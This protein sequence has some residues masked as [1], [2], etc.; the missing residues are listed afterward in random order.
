MSI[1]ALS[2]SGLSPASPVG[3]AY[4][5]SLTLSG[6]VVKN[7]YT[8][9]GVT[10]TIGTVNGT[11]STITLAG[12]NAAWTSAMAAN[13]VLQ[14]TAGT[15]SLGTGTVTVTSVVSSTSVNISST[16]AMTAGTIT[17]LLIVSYGTGVF[18]APASLTAN[19]TLS[20]NGLTLS[21]DKINVP[22]SNIRINSFN[23]N[24]SG[25][26]GTIGTVAGSGSAWTANLTVSDTSVLHVGMKVTSAATGTSAGAVGT[27]AVI[28]SITNSTVAVIFSTT[29]STAG[30][31]TYSFT[32]LGGM[33][34]QIYADTLSD[35]KIVGA[36]Q[37]SIWG[38][39]DKTDDGLNAI[40][41][42]SAKIT[43]R[44]FTLSFPTYTE[45]YVNG[46][47]VSSSY[48]K[49][50]EFASPVSI[51]GRLRLRAPAYTSQGFPTG[52]PSQ[53]RLTIESETI[54]SASSLATV[55]GITLTTS[56]TVTGTWAVGQEVRG[57]GITAGSMVTAVSGPTSG[58]YTVTLDRSS[59]INTPTALTGTPTIWNIDNFGGLFRI[60]REDWSTDTL[61]S[62]ITGST[63]LV[64]TNAGEVGI[65]TNPVNAQLHVAAD[66]FASTAQSILENT[67]T[68]GYANLLIR[69]F[70]STY[71][72][73]SLAGNSTIMFFTN[74][75][76][77]T[78]RAR[79]VI[80]S[81]SNLYFTTGAYSTERMRITSSG[82]VG[83]GTSSPS[84]TLHVTGTVAGAVAPRCVIS[85]GSFIPNSVGPT[86]AYIT[87][88]SD[89]YE[90]QYGDGTDRIAYTTF[91]V[92]YN[93]SG[94]SIQI[95][96]YW[97]ISSGINSQVRWEGWAS[98][99]VSS[100]AINS[101]PAIV[102]S[103]NA[104]V[105]SGA[106]AGTLIISTMTWSTSLP[107]AGSLLYFGLKRV[108]SNT[109]DTSGA[110]ANVQAVAFE[111][112]S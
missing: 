61:Y 98:S 26:S 106:T 4:A 18:S 15:G 104:G 12:T 11:T 102:A 34:W 70:G 9:T 76:G 107:A 83:I 81:N 2:G 13:A 93:Y 5:S 108:P 6:G 38:Y 40:G 29:T 71:S 33:H 69:S 94:G 100:G 74:S 105:A 43:E 41:S 72:S 99:V 57:S 19:T 80:D 66:L 55:S 51:N 84:A 32:D 31:S 24:V 92:P 112:G 85:P 50:A 91:S 52:A 111:F 25:I 44:F 109:N 75:D 53:G 1:R 56:G 59:T 60:F 48:T 110:S 89:K 23:A 49:L 97:Y 65:G 42:A 10:I 22:Y 67:A 8:G 73:L 58:V 21:P 36:R 17:N 7:P 46:A 47:Y 30:S 54:I 78:E 103:V 64:I 90:L 86:M 3:N 87:S 28:Q 39:P 88:G 77:S 14:A 27:S 62:G 68:T 35:T 45:T 37:F 63:K 95:K 101:D 79:I 82:N 16:A 20:A 96:I